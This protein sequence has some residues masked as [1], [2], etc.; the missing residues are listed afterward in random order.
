MK[1]LVDT[2]Y[3]EDAQYDELMSLLRRARIPVHETRTHL[4]SFGAL[5]VPDESFDRA[6]EI[7]RNESTAFAARARQEWEREWELQHRGS[8]L[9][10]FAYRLLSDPM[11]VLLRVLL[12]ALILGAFLLYPLWVILR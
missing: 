4:L 11:E 10:W 9:R 7:L 6:R 2:R 5:W 1:R 8:A 3:L 12:L